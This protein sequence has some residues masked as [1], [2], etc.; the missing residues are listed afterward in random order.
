MK[1]LKNETA[2][3]YS[4]ATLCSA[5]LSFI[6]SSLSSYNKIFK[7]GEEPLKISFVIKFVAFFFI[8]LSVQIVLKRYSHLHFFVKQIFTVFSKTNATLSS[9]LCGILVFFFSYYFALQMPVDYG[10]H[11]NLAN[12]LN[13]MDFKG[14]VLTYS[15]PLWHV[16]VKI[17]NLVLHMPIDHSAALAS[18]LFILLT[19]R[20]TFGII[21]ENAKNPFAKRY[22]AAFSAML[23]F[24]QPI[25]LPWFNQHQIYGQ[26]SPNIMHNPTNIATKPFAII[27]AYLIVQMLLKAR[28]HEKIDITEYIKLSFFAFVSVIA[29]PSTIQ[30]ILPALAV[31]LV[32][33]L[34]LSVKQH[35]SFCIKICLSWLPALCY[36]MF[37]FFL[38]FVSDS[39]GVEGGIS[40]SFFDV[41]K[42]FSNCIPLS[43]LLVMLFPIVEIINC[44][45]NELDANKLGMLF[46]FV[47]VAIGIIE[48]AFIMETG[49]RKYHGNFSWGYNIALGVI[50]T[51]A[52]SHLLTNSDKKYKKIAWNISCSLFF[53]YFIY[54]VYYYFS[55]V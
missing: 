23:M 3:F 55:V 45:K 52:V 11:A 29:K 4:I 35:F 54:G 34:F 5:I 28:N 2:K 16:L 21:A 33:M 32:L 22:A 48:Y 47:C 44:R 51:F 25:Y 24:V 42:A 12:S 15:T 18:S 9:L 1:K 6:L 14:T 53:I 31:F 30:V 13:F 40:L 39:V 36:M 50:W 17:I 38:N 8:I 7:I 27:C 19:Y 46:G 49:E 41:W 37:S 20:V 43:I 26:G 10:F